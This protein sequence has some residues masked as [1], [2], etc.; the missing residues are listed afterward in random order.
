MTDNIVIIG[1]GIIGVCTAYYLSQDDRFKSRSM[2]VTI[3]EANDIA[4]GASGKAAGF[5]TLDWH[6]PRTASLAELSYGLHEQL[7]NELDGKNAYGYRRLTT[8]E[9]CVRV[10]KESTDPLVDPIF[11]ARPEFQRRSESGTPHTEWLRGQNFE[12]LMLLAEEGENTTAQLHPLQFTKILFKKAQEGGVKY[13]KGRPESWEEH[14][15][16]LTINTPNGIQNIVAD[17]LVIAAGPWSSQVSKTLFNLDLPIS[18]LP[19][20]SILIRPMKVLPAFAIF[21]QIY[22][23]EVTETPEIF[24]RPDGHVYVAGENQGPPLPEGTADVKIDPKAIRKLVNAASNVSDVLSN[25]VVEVEQLCYR[26]VTPHGAPLIGALLPTHG[27]SFLAS[28]HGPWGILL[29]PGTGKVMAEL[30]LDGSV[31][32]ADISQLDPSLFVNFL[33]AC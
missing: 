17:T 24:L 16:Y 32:S 5:L 1:G 31:N 19:G 3:V 12:N 14:S 10:N 27:K 25:G 15:K 2:S 30:I 4:S 22:A 33:S 7:A 28:G 18:N 8:L 9:L 20:H 13:I 21:A 6:G 23:S 26:P 11:A 29:G